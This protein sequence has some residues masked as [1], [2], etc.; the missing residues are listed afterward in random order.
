MCRICSTAVETRC[1]LLDWTRQDEEMYGNSCAAGLLQMLTAVRHSPWQV[2][3]SWAV[4]DLQRALTAC[5]GDSSIAA[6]LKE[7][8]A[9]ARSLARAHALQSPGLKAKP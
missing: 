2:L 3:V 8:S 9:E 5:P 6:A 4:R 7:A 1:T